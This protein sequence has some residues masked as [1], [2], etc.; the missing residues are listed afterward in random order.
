M[1]R[2]DIKIMAGGGLNSNN[3]KDL[4][5]LTGCQEYHTTAKRWEESNVE[6]K[7]NLKLNGSSDIPE[8]KRMVA[9]ADEVRILRDLI[10][11]NFNCV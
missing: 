1:G 4:I 2:N 10:D 5:E 9:S 8:D 7:T 6:F 11:K 3:I